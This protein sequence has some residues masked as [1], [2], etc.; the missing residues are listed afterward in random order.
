MAMFLLLPD[1]RRLIHVLVL[2][3]PAPPAELRALFHG[4]WTARVALVARNLALVYLLTTN[5]MNASR[6]IQQFQARSPLRGIYDVEEFESNGPARWR[7]V[8]FDRARGFTFY[9]ENDNRQRRQITLD[10][11][12][13]A[14]KIAGEGGVLRYEQPE[15]GILVLSGE[16]GGSKIRA[17]LRRDDK[18][19]FLLLNRGFHWISEYPFNR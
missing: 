15:P 8:I 18:R 4:K 17:R 10:E 6:S 2:N 14:L 16:F 5:L 7:R 9:L 3:R 1:L 19:A 11:K 12:E 13:R